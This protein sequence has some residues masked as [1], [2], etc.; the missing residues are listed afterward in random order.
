MNW[1]AGEDQAVLGPRL[2]REYNVGK[3]TDCY[4]CHR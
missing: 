3:L 1:V 2:V 4:T